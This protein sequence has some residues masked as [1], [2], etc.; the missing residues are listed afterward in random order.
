MQHSWQ[1]H[2][3]LSLVGCLNY[4]SSGN[5]FCWKLFQHLAAIFTFSTVNG[6]QVFLITE[7]CLQKVMPPFYLLL[8]VS[9]CY[10]DM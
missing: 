1:H 9:A 2:D 8:L 10:M 3:F 6:L 7:Y 5:E 4:K